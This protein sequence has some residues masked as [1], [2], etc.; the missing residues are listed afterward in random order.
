MSAHIPHARSLEQPIRP[1]TMRDIAARLGIHYTTVSL[2]LKDSPRI[3][4]T[5]RKLVWQIAESMGYQRNP[6]VEAFNHRRLAIQPRVRTEAVAY[7]VDSPLGPGDSGD[8]RCLLLEA[9]RAVAPTFGFSPEVF[10]TGNDLRPSRVDSILR[11][12]NTTFIM[13]AC[14]GETFNDLELDWRRLIG[15]RIGSF[16][17][18]APLDIVA[19]DYYQ[20][21]RL[22]VRH[23]RQ[24]GYRRIGLALSASSDRRTGGFWR[25]GYAAETRPEFPHSAIDPLLLD[26]S[27]QATAAEFAVWVTHHALDAVITENT[28]I[29]ETCRRHGVRCPDA[30]GWVCLD[31]DRVGPHTTAIRTDWNLIGRTAVQLLDIRRQ[32]IHT[33]PFGNLSNCLLPVTLVSRASSA[34]KPT[35]PHACDLAQTLT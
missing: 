17:S 23:L 33:E 1:V 5:T 4:A 12:R 27:S 14:L 8:V 34:P 20:A 30:L 35:G 25:A 11:F 26:L 31:G 3:S 28:E 19:P 13:L 32:A 9:V 2:A 16:Q 7:V 29:V 10:V 24:Q 22:A 18:T 6:L 21:A 15:L